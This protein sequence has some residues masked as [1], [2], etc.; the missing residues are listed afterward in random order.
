MA[1]LTLQKSAFNPFRMTYWSFGN[2]ISLCD[3]LGLHHM[4]IVIIFATS[5][6]IILQRMADIFDGMQHLNQQQD[7]MQNQPAGRNP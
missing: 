7:S 3:G 1:L 5:S 2:I 6:L 4:R